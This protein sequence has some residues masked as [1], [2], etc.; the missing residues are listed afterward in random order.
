MEHKITGV[1]DHDD[2]LREVIFGQRL[3]VRPAVSLAV[4]SV[5][6]LAISQRERIRQL[7]AAEREL[8]RHKAVVASLEDQLALEK[9]RCAF[10][11]RL[12]GQIAELSRWEDD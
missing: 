1:A 7:E 2:V 11:E 4:G 6:G 3:L 9:D 12:L 8:E 10:M 5:V